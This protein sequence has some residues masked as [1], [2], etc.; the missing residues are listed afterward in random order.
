MK[1]ITQHGII[2]LCVFTGLLAGFS[3]AEGESGKKSTI[4]GS[5]SLDSN[6]ILNI[7][8]RVSVTQGN[9]SWTAAAKEKDDL[10]FKPNLAFGA[11]HAFLRF[12]QFEIL[13]G[14][15][16]PQ[17]YK[18]TRLYKHL[19]L[20]FVGEASGSASLDEGD[21]EL[22]LTPLYLKPRIFFSPVSAENITAYAAIKLSYNFISISGG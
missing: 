18:A 17:K 2:Y 6:L 9:S 20:T 5:T 11:E 7:S 12:G 3:F 10:S 19:S 1:K 16:L 13:G 8:D 4:K 14:F 22:N 15:T 21:F